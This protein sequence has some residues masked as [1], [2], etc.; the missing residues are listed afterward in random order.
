[1][2]NKILDSDSHSVAGDDT[3][4][5]FLIQIIITECL[6]WARHGAVCSE[7][8]NEQRRLTIFA[9]MELIYSSGEGKE[10]RK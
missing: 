3:I 6:L 8:I 5:I 7:D 4:S 2:L 1:M 10:I 9:S